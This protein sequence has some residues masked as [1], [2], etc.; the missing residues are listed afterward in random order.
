MGAKIQLPDQEPDIFWP[1]GLQT[2]TSKFGS[3]IETSNGGACS[4]SPPDQNVGLLNVLWCTPSHIP[5]HITPCTFEI[6]KSPQIV[7]PMNSKPRKHM[8][9]VQSNKLCVRRVSTP[10]SKV[11]V[12]RGAFYYFTLPFLRSKAYWY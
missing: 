10:H 9:R 2:F 4:E 11:P 3:N 5:P 7:L 6:W 12:P 8:Q 1:K